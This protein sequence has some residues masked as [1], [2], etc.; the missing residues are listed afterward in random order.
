[1]SD[2]KFGLIF[3]GFLAEFIQFIAVLLSIN[4]CAVGEQLSVLKKI[5]IINR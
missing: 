1:M 4:S 3:D 5:M 2:E